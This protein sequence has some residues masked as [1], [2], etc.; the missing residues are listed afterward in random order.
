MIFDKKQAPSIWCPAA[1]VA[2]HADPIRS[3]ATG[4]I[5]S[6]CAH[7]RQTDEQ[8]GYCGGGGKPV[9]TDVGPAREQANAGG[10]QRIPHQTRPAKSNFHR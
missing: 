8:H 3:G 10:G 1:P 5:W 7:F 9:Q 2:S 4:C 6:R